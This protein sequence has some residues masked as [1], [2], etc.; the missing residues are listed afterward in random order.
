MEAVS[1]AAG[2]RSCHLTVTNGSQM[3]GSQIEVTGGTVFNTFAC[4]SSAHEIADRRS[5]QISAKT[6]RMEAAMTRENKG[7]K[8][9]TNTHNQDGSFCVAFLALGSIGDCLPLC[10]LAST[11]VADGTVIVTH[12]HHVSCLQG[13]QKSGRE[14][15]GW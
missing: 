12:V 13:E 2:S 1:I 3:N 7:S 15:V 6:I 14:V 5:A 9:D 4:P 11:A 10:A 8:S